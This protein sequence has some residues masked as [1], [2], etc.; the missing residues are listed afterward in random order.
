[1]GTVVKTAMQAIE[2]VIQ[3]VEPSEVDDFRR[4]V[5]KLYGS[6]GIDFRRDLLDALGPTTV[7]YTSPGEGPFF[8][9]AGLIIAIPMTLTL[10]PAG[11]VAAKARKLTRRTFP[12][13]E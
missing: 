6:F 13:R 12:A 3:V 5:K 2:D 1:M 9:G 7:I 8:L 4:E 11:R 10:E